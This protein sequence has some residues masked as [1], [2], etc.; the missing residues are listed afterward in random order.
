MSG[1]Y[2]D[3]FTAF[4]SSSSNAITALGTWNTGNNCLY[5][6]S[7]ATCT[8]ATSTTSGC[9]STASWTQGVTYWFCPWGGRYLFNSLRYH[10]LSSLI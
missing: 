1:Y 3:Q 7:G 10:H 6:A 4:M 2:Y 8:I 9:S 5:Y